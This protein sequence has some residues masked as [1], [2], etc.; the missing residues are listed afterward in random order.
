MRPIESA[1]L[2]LACATAQAQ[3]P[4]PWDQ[5]KAELQWRKGGAGQF[6]LVLADRGMVGKPWS[7][8]EDAVRLLVSGAMATMVL[9]PGQFVKASEAF[10]EV[11]KTRW[12]LLGPPG[13]VLASGDRDPDVP[14]M[15]A[16]MRSTGWKPRWE[17]RADLLRDHPQLGDVVAAE[18]MA[19]A[20]E[21]LFKARNQGREK[22]RT[23]EELASLSPAQW[24]EAGVTRVSRALDAML[25]VPDWDLA[26]HYFFFDSLGAL[27]RC[28]Q[29]QP[30]LGQ[31]LE[32]LRDM[33][34][35][36]PRDYRVWET[37]GTMLP[38]L[39]V[40]FTTSLGAEIEP[41][42]GQ[43]FL[44][45]EEFRL[46]CRLLARDKAWDRLEAET[47]RVLDK[48]M[49]LEASPDR[50]PV[51]QPGN[52]TYTMALLLG[53]PRL[54]ALLNLGRVE[55]AL[56]YL[57][58]LRD[59]SGTTWRMIA[60]A[61]TQ[62]L[63]QRD[64][65]GLKGVERIL[66]ALKSEALEAKPSEPPIPYRIAWSLRSSS[67]QDLEKLKRDER[68]D[69]W[70]DRELL[71]KALEPEERSGLEGAPSPAEEASWM[72]LRGRSVLAWGRGR[73]QGETIAD[74]L[75]RYGTP[76]LAKLRTF[77]KHHPSRQDALGLF[78][79][80]LRRRPSDARV[81]EQ[82]RHRLPSWRGDL[83]GF[84]S[85]PESHDP[86]SWQSLA[87]KLLPS[88]EEE[89]GHWPGSWRAWNRWLFWSRFHPQHPQAAALLGRLPWVPPAR[90][91]GSGL[92]SNVLSIVQEALKS[93][94][95]W[96]GLADWCRAVWEL[97]GRR[98]T[99]AILQRP[100]FI[101]SGYVDPL[102]ELRESRSLILKPWEEALVQLGET[103]KLKALQAE[104]K[105]IGY[106]D[107]GQRPKD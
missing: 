106:K 51:F 67:A 34:R 89:L 1:L 85:M 12:F 74:A 21:V 81:E 105:A 50:S 80:L 63:G 84:A 95:D 15:L 47:A 99:E 62:Q 65:K 55:D 58:G 68:F 97:D 54:E 59:R 57:S 49:A 69:D 22:P 8:S 83:V 33:I 37:L 31:V 64:L 93:R 40:D 52:T 25:A 101:R 53:V 86:E 77:L 71:W 9:G 5:V 100:A 46:H 24:D 39:P 20:G 19:T 42:P 61:I 87:M 107:P 48:A 36:D 35:E 104:L 91:E 72:L 45:E 23:N 70:T 73:I 79:Q 98:R 2:A 7:L 44:C 18:F 41:L 82:L 90:V 60:P 30:V 26:E 17:E 88:I 29:L 96:R 6:R 27:S 78:L 32:R 4:V 75:A 14:A 103:E 43:A 92:N 16:A 38:L 94:K 76:Y 11:A 10:P 66:D 28:P 102:G 56:G 3:A 13:S